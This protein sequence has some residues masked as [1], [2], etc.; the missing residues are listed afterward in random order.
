VY[1]SRVPSEH[2]GS[3]GIPE[4]EETIIDDAAELTMLDVE[5]DM[6]PPGPGPTV[7]EA[8]EPVD[9]GPAPPN[10]LELEALVVIV[11]LVLVV[12]LVLIVAP[13]L[14]CDV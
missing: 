13:V 8:S 14:T 3:S 1:A 7:D 2:P 10:P 12:A 5:T 4:L 11:A 6:L 9:V